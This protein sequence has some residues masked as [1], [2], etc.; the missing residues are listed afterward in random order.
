MSRERLKAALRALVHDARVDTSAMYAGVVLRDHGDQRLDVRLDKEGFPDLVS[1]P[2]WTFLPG[3]SVEVAPQT[4]VLVGFAGGDPAQPYAQLFQAGGLV[5]VTVE[6]SAVVE[7]VAPSVDLGGGGGPGVARSGD[8]VEVTIPPGAVMV[9]NPA[10]G[11][12][13]PSPTAITLAGSVT[14]GSSTVKAV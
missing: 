13:I 4:R 7:L 9:P 3:V 5:R 1:I 11:P 2:L 6:A 8:P 14:S 12:A 10:G